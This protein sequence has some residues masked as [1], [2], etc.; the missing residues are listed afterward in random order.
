MKIYLMLG[1]TIV[2]FLS[3]CSNI[4]LQDTD[5][6]PPNVNL[7]IHSIPGPVESLSETT[8]FYGGVEFDRQITLNSIN[9]D[10]ESGI[11]NFSISAEFD[12]SCGGVVEGGRFYQ[13]PGDVNNG[14]AP[15]GA[16]REVRPVAGGQIVFT[17]RD[18]I[19]GPRTPCVP[20]YRTDIFYELRGS[21]RVSATNYVGLRSER[22]FPVVISTTTVP[23]RPVP[24][25]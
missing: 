22:V 9:N 11:R 1:S 23:T 21:V 5:I 12:R 7:T 16:N 6:S 13:P 24:E 20:P 8:T 15:A 10:Y 18:A 2:L 3:A 19:S 17:L 4:P 14:P 25:E